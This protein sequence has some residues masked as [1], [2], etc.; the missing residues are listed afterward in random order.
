MPSAYP[1]INNQE[2]FD[3]PGNNDT[4]GHEMEIKNAILIKNCLKKGLKIKLMLIVS[5]H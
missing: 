4:G 5:I 3:L 2:L 1:W